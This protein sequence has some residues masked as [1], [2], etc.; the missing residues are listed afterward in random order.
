MSD[1]LYGKRIHLEVLSTQWTDDKDDVAFQQQK[2][3]SEKT[4]TMV[5]SLEF[6]TPFNSAAIAETQL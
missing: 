5:Q 2:T 1:I 3:F 4:L 6:S